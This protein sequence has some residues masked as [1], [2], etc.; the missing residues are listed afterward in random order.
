MQVLS[1][2]RVSAR[3]FR[4]SLRPEGGR[5]T[6]FRLGRLAWRSVP[7][8]QQKPWA[9]GRAH[10]GV[11]IF[12]VSRAGRGQAPAPPATRWERCFAVRGQIASP[13]SGGTSLAPRRDAGTY[14]STPGNR[15][16]C[17]RQQPLVILGKSTKG[18]SDLRGPRSACV[19]R[20]IAVLRC[21]VRTR[22]SRRRQS[23][24]RRGG[25]L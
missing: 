11:G 20:P 5:P 4:I 21:L 13:T 9:E 1:G 12:G 23:R 17:A 24:G 2:Y 25:I 19:D 10:P 8:T 14:R 18:A 7:G 15:E 3:V 22:S 16:V 6:R